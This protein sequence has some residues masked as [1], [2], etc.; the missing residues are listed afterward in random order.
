MT[1][2]HIKAKGMKVSY[3]Q[4]QQPL[5]VE[6]VAVV[7]HKLDIPE[8][9]PVGFYCRRELAENATVPLPV[10]EEEKVVSDVFHIRVF[11]VSRD[12]PA[13]VHLPLYKVASEKEQLVLRFIDSAFEDRPVDG[14]ITG[15][16]VCG[17]G[18]RVSFYL[19]IFT[20]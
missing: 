19:F 2:R 7:L 17:I 12:C 11:D 1:F 15:K 14:V 20:S 3:Q 4:T 16:K 5:R 8:G 18:R 13:V 10:H 6:R 9:L